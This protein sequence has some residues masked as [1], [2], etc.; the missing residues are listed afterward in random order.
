MHGRGSRHRHWNLEEAR[1]EAGRVRL[2]TEKGVAAAAGGMEAT[3]RGNG[4]IR[5]WESFGDIFTRSR[6]YLVVETIPRAM[7]LLNRF[8]EADASVNFLFFSFSKAGMFSNCLLKFIV[9]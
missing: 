5:V 1:Q 8:L 2:E 7:S 4:C 6:V 3:E 9:S